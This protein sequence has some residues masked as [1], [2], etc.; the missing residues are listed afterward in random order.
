MDWADVDSQGNQWRLSVLDIFTGVETA[1]SET[2]LCMS[3][4]T[5]RGQSVALPHFAGQRL[6][7]LQ[8]HVAPEAAFAEEARGVG[9]A[10]ALFSGLRDLRTSICHGQTT[11][12][13]DRQGKWHLS[14]RTLIFKDGKAHRDCLVLDGDEA[15]QISKQLRAAAQSL[16]DLLANMRT[17][18]AGQSNPSFANSLASLGGSVS[19][20]SPDASA[21]ASA[22]SR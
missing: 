9:K 18:I 17:R 12:L 6:E 16:C 20:A 5:G 10:I 11:M 13:A 8:K 21:G 19:P 2:L 1:V 3:K 15:K 7:E 14:I 22:A 4:V